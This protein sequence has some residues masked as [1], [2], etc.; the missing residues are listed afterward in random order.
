MALRFGHS[1]LQ[2][3]IYLEDDVLSYGRAVCC[4]IFESRVHFDKAA[5]LSSKKIIP[6]KYQFLPE[7]DMHAFGCPNNAFQKNDY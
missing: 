4:C 2:K 7:L 6:W 3:G 1:G 5:R